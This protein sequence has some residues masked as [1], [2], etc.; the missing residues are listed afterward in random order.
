VNQPTDKSR[1]GRPP[2]V[3]L[4]RLIEAEH[5]WVTTFV[6]MRDGVQPTRVE[7]RG[8]SGIFIKASGTEDKVFVDSPEGTIETTGRE[9]LYA[10]LPGGEPKIIRQP[11]IL[12]KDEMAKW[13]EKTQAFEN[14]FQRTAMGKEVRIETDPGKPPELKLWE[15]LKRARTAAQVRKIYRRSTIWLIHRLDFPSGGYFDWSW[16]PFPKALYD[17]AAE[18]CRAKLDPRY[19]KRDNRESGDYRRIEY[20]ARAMAGRCLLKPISESYS[21]ELLRKLKH[22]DSCRCWRCQYQI[23]PRFPRTL[24]QYLMGQR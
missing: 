14:D 15:A 13:Q 17:D 22:L 12:S 5:F 21:V 8:G 20:L 7:A 23:A 1:F 6:G 11:K 19:P 2:Q 10:S 3:N 9:T 18:F 4:E 16:S 24:A